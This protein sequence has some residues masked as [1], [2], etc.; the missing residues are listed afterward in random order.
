[1]TAGCKKNWYGMR[2]AIMSNGDSAGKGPLPYGF[3]A[4]DRP[5]L[6]LIVDLHLQNS[7]RRNSSRLLKQVQGKQ[8]VQTYSPESFS[9]IVDPTNEVQIAVHR[10]R[11]SVSSCNAAWTAYP[12]WIGTRIKDFYGGNIVVSIVPSH[13]E[14]ET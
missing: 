12:P 5:A 2:S 11:A 13:S 1:M 14:S 7:S 6:P 3:A 8:V 10:H 4:R 9:S